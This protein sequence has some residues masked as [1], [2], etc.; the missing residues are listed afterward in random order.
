MKYGKSNSPWV[1]KSEEKLKAREAE[2]KQKEEELERIRNDIR[3]Q[4]GAD[5]IVVNSSKVNKSKAIEVND[6]ERCDSAGR[7][8]HKVTKQIE[9]LENK[10]RNKSALGHNPSA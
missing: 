2:L 1:K 5:K 10:T 7:R 9:M 6:V 3:K 4:T 8:E